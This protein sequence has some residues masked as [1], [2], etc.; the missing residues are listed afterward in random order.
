MQWYGNKTKQ[1]KIDQPAAVSGRNSYPGINRNFYPGSISDLK[2]S[3]KLRTSGSCQDSMFSGLYHRRIRVLQRIA[4]SDL[5]NVS[6]AM[7]F[8]DLRN[9]S[10]YVPSS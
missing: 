1:N 4:F 10:N 5:R 6:E 9:V 2:D 7:A 3:T 8:S